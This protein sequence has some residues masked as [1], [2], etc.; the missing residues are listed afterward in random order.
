MQKYRIL[1]QFRSKLAITHTIGMKRKEKYNAVVV[2]CHHSLY[3]CD[4]RMKISLPR[5]FFFF[6]KGDPLLPGSHLG[7]N[8]WP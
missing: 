5:F 8:F 1:C 7:R 2:D 3:L 6:L 4:D